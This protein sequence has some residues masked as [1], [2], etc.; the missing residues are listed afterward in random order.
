MRQDDLPIHLIAGTNIA[1]LCFAQ[2]R[3]MMPGEWVKEI[4]THS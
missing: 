1:L 2:G 4:G 3:P